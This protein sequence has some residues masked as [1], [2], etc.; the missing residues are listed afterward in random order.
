MWPSRSD[1]D[2]SS[3]E[4]SW[5]PPHELMSN[6]QLPEAGPL[7][8][9]LFRP[10]YISPSQ[11]NKI[12][13]IDWICTAKLGVLPVSIKPTER[14]NSI[15]IFK[16]KTRSVL[17][18]HPHGAQQSTVPRLTRS[19]KLKQKWT[20]AFINTLEEMTD[21]SQITYLAVVSG[22]WIFTSLTTNM[23]L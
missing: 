12:V 16:M 23:V 14:D 13:F 1:G 7:I 5:D 17:K 19:G 21:Q 6:G 2:L 3:E 10:S 15:N 8:P 18:K 11:T 4:S 20:N 22:A 9:T